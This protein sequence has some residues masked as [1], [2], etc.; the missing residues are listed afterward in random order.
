MLQAPAMPQAVPESV[1]EEHTIY[2]DY[3]KFRYSLSMPGCAL[4][5]PRP[6]THMYF[7]L[8]LIEREER[9]KPSVDRELASLAV[10]G[11]VREMMEKTTPV[12]LE[13]LFKL[14]KKRR[15]VILIEGPPGSGK[16]TLSWHLCQK[17][18]KGEPFPGF[19]LVI[20]VQLRDP[21]I[22]SAR[23]IADLLPR[24][25]DQMAREVLADM[26]ARDGE[27]VLFVLDGW[28]E[29]PGDL[30]R[31]SPLRQLMEPS[32]LTPFQRSSVIIT[33]RPE[34][35][36]EL[37]NLAS[38]RVQILGFTP[39]KVEEYFTESLKNEPE[40]AKSLMER[41]KEN[42][43]I[44]GSC[45]LPLNAAIV[46][47]LFLHMG[48]L[49][50]TLTGIFVALVLHCILRHCKARTNFRIRSLSSLDSLPGE[51]QKSFDSLC[52]LAYQGI[53]VNQIL[54]TEQDVGVLPEFATLSLLQAVES[55]VTVGSVK[56]YHFLH[57]SVQ[58]LLAAWYISR[59]PADA[60][61]EVMI[62]RLRGHERFSGVFRFYAGLTHLHVPWNKDFIKLMVIQTKGYFEV[63]LHTFAVCI[64]KLR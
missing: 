15:K 10:E 2:A 51:L 33:T 46:I 21:A 9:E 35:S 52:M 29:L 58:E 13:D 56:M 18:G 32:V 16:T 34:E 36:A 28:D 3:L 39:D 44:E 43:A 6:P 19:E 57:L 62:H 17:W 45:S 42:P 53:L 50:S 20:Y 24:R 14:D 59:M 37:R 27:G 64:Q 11:R 48:Q 7:D 23:S 31:D 1:S 41:V 49:P 40:Q 63:S 22:H 12:K 8:A 26:E 61:L 5:F 47:T 60:Q 25:N 4:Q 55:F 30:P 54:F 38:S